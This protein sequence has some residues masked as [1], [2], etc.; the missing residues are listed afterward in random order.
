MS[1][2]ARF[3]LTAPLIGLLSGCGDPLSAPDS[4]PEGVWGGPH[5]KLVLTADEG[6]LEYDC[7]HGVL[8]TPVSV[9]SDGRFA[10]TG[11]HTFERGGPVREGEAPDTHAAT[12]EGRLVGDRITFTVTVTDFGVLGPFT[13]ARGE[14]G[15]VFKCL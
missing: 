13:L 11:T 9:Q 4:L 6:D 15:Q 14:A 1:S 12:Y 7:A 8:T 3:L 5:A 10:A 2:R